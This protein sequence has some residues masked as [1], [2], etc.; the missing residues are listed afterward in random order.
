M[1]LQFVLLALGMTACGVAQTF[2]V[3]IPFEFRV[4]N[5]SYASGRYTVS[6]GVSTADPS[7]VWALRSSEARKTTMF[8]TNADVSAVPAPGSRLVF[9]KYG[10]IYFLSEVWAQTRPGRQLHASRGEREMAKS[11]GPGELVAVN[12]V[13]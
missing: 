7:G 6:A 8:F 13:R 12:P 2:T 1:R 9:H 5:H 4:S 11:I 10:N 3:D